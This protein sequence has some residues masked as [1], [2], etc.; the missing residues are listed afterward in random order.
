MPMRLRPLPTVAAAVLL[1]GAPAPAVAQAFGVP[2]GVGAVTIAWQYISNTGHRLSDG[3]YNPGPR[4]QSVSQ[5]A[6][7]E[8]EYGVTPRLSASLGIPYVWAKYTGSQ[9]APSLL[10]VDTCGCWHSSFADFSVG[11][12]YRFGGATWALTPL[13]RYGYPSHDYAY[14][15][16]AVVGR[17]LNELQLGLA[18]GT[19]LGGF[20]SA[21]TA[22]ATYGYSFVESPLPDV[23]IDKSTL[24][25]DVGYAATR[26]LYLRAFGTGVYTHGGLRAGSPTGNPFLFPGDLAPIGGERWQQRDRVLATK[27]WQLGA[28]LA[29]SLGATDV[30]ASY[31]NYVWGRDA[32]NGWSL[33]LG[34]TWYFER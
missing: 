1:G 14:Q 9:P 24:S 23:S 3:Y 15:G 2:D 22:Q 7:A 13:V 8:I 33:N 11:A 29:Y 17:N 30:F 21:V 25:L 16:E 34:T 28:G 4:G 32:H 19:K 20:L 5:S 12:R 10:P 27:Y 6:L 31:S 26:R 18:A